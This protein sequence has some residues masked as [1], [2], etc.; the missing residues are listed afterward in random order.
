MK[1][2]DRKRTAAQSSA[3][4]EDDGLANTKIA[5]LRAIS[6]TYVKKRSRNYW[7]GSPFVAPAR[8]VRLVLVGPLCG[9]AGFVLQG[10][11]AANSATL[12]LHET[13]APPHQR[14]PLSPPPLVLPI[15][16]FRDLSLLW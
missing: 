1:S 10:G 7:L 2:Q 8:S 12:G 13:P 5:Q 15:C 9:G 11:R 3:Y 4:G 6:A 16:V 14:P